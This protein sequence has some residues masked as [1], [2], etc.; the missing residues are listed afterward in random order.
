MTVLPGTGVQVETQ[1]DVR[2]GHV[3]LHNLLQGAVRPAGA[4]SA[5]EQSIRMRMLA[6]FD[7]R[8]D[9]GPAMQADL[10]V[11]QGIDAVT[12][13]PAQLAAGIDLMQRVISLVVR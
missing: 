9:R 10:L 13:G 4:H 5:V 12:L 11:E 8:H 1:R 7:N 3:S 2:M 6:T